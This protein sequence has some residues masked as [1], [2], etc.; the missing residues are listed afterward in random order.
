MIKNG[1]FPFKVFQM[2]YEACV[3]SILEYGSEVFGFDDHDS[4]LKIHLRAARSYLGVPKNSPIPGIIS[5]FNQLLPHYKGQI[6]MI[7]QYNRLLKSSTNNVSK[8]IFEWDT[9]LNEQ[10]IINS[11][12]NEAKSIFENCN[13]SET[14]QGGFLFYLKSTFNTAKLQILKKQQNRIPA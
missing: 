2:L 7:R 11:W 9:N 14:F 8:K 10:N 12:Y 1:G 4:A 6:K 13:L 5:E 3:C